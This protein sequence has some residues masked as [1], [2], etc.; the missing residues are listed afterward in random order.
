MVNIMTYT[1]RDHG[2]YDMHDRRIAITRGSG[3]YNYNNHRV[4][5]MLG[6]FLFDL[7]NRKMMEVRGEYIYDAKDIR[8][9]S[10]L[11]AKQSIEGKSEENLSVALWYCFIR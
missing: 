10:L 2:L 1:I 6:N 7:D 3:I 4:A 9:G 8:V 5:T 11:D